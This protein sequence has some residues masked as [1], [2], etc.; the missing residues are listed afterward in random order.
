MGFQFGFIVMFNG[1]FVG[2]VCKMEVNFNN[3]EEIMVILGIKLEIFVKVDIKVFMFLQG[4]MGLKYIDLQGSI[5]EVKCLEEG[6]EIPVG[7]GF[8][9]R[10]TDC[11]D[12]FLVI[13]DDIMR[14]FVYIICEEN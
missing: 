8:I 13:V 3:V 4:I 7:V 11:V 9:D 14:N 1:V 6:F 10:F 12:E 2:Q 5:K